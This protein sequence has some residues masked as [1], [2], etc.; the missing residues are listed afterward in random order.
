MPDDAQKPISHIERMQAERGWPAA[1]TLFVVIAGSFTTF[2]ISAHLAILIVYGPEAW[3]D[4]LR[5]ISMKPPLLSN[6]SEPTL[7]AELIHG[8]GGFLLTAALA[9]GSGLLFT[10]IKMRLTGPRP[11]DLDEDSS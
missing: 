11:R 4:G 9:I 3:A 2:R 1:L 5:I 7:A 6:G 8:F 10:W